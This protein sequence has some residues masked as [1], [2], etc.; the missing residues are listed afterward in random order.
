MKKGAGSDPFASNSD[1]V[2]EGENESEVDE[3][4]TD[5]SDDPEDV[6]PEEPSHT[7]LLKTSRSQAETGIEL[8]PPQA[9]NDGSGVPWVYTRKNVKQDRDMVQFYLREF[10]QEAEG[11]FVDVIG[12]QLSHDVSKTDVRE[13]AY[14]AAMRRPEIVVDELERWGFEGD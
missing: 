7:E 13:A 6:E 1:D 10:V 12:A 9:G 4:E 5:T 8:E 2:D 11:E 3:V 14:V